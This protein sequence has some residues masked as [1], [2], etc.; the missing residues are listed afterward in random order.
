MVGIK[1]ITAAELPQRSE[2]IIYVVKVGLVLYFA[3]GTA[4]Y[5]VKNWE[6]VGLYPALLSASSEIA[7]FFMSA[8]NNNDPI[9]F[10]Q[11]R[12]EGF[13]LLEEREIPI[14]AAIRNNFCKQLLPKYVLDSPSVDWQD[15]EI[16]A[17]F[18]CCWKR[19]R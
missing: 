11:Y 5:E 14:S 10:C 18:S 3:T 15:V 4:W 9:G 8:Q 1:I 6:K 17:G 12:L 2:L 7:G 16:K 19:K 13:N